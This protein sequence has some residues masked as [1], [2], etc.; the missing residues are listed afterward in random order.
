MTSHKQGYRHCDVTLAV[1][2]T[3]VIRVKNIFCVSIVNTIISLIYFLSLSNWDL[4][5][6]FKSKQLFLKPWSVTS[7]RALTGV[8]SKRP[9]VSPPSRIDTLR[10]Y[11]RHQTPLH[12]L[13][14]TGSMLWWMYLWLPLIH[15]GLP[16]LNSL[17]TTSW[18]SGLPMVNTLTSAYIQASQH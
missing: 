2:T 18:H 12:L 15:S 17:L 4:F 14:L 6:H 1:M 9:Y 3:P 11:K 7:W 5:L 13:S 16:T 8:P 10:V